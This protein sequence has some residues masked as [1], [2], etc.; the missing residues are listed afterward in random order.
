MSSGRN[1]SPDRMR[2]RLA[3][4][5]T[6]IGSGMT[7]QAHAQARGWNTGNCGDGRCGRCGGGRG[8]RR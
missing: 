4:L 5:D 8:G 7:L 2:E 1:F 3:G 6:T